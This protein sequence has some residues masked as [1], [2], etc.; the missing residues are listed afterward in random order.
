M[1][2]K[3]FYCDTETTGTFYWVNGLIQFS[4]VIEIDGVE[5]ERLNLRIAPFKDDVIDDVALEHNRVTRE[6]LQ[7]LD[8]VSPKE[9]HQIITTTLAKYVNKFDPKDKFHWIG[10]RAQF[11]ADFTR[12]FFRK[13]GDTFFGSWFYTPVLCVMTLAGYLLQRERANLENFKQRTVY[14]YLHPGSSFTDENWHDSMFD[15]ERA[16]DIEAALRQRVIRGISR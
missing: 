15:I 11:D 2:G 4:A 3:R 12:E 8:R 5:M 16:K 10:Y 6:D 7:A 9:A 14:E 13:L 1:F